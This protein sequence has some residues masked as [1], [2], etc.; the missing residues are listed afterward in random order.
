MTETTSNDNQPKR[1]PGD[2]REPDPH[3]Q[4]AM[5]LVES[6]LHGL[7]AR[8]ALSN[9]DALEIVEIA[10]AVKEEFADE[11]GDSKPTMERSLA[12]LGAIHQSLS[13]DKAR[14]D[15]H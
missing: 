13:R 2:L 5:L 9:A 6:L 11:V 4:A 3:G 8:S 10:A 14:S 1:G 15:N 12:L 7:I